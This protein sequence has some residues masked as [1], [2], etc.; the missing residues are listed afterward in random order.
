MLSGPSTDD[1]FLNDLRQAI[2]G[3]YV[4]TDAHDKEPYLADWRGYGKGEAL[5]VVL[6]ASTEQVSNLMRLA[7]IHGSKIVPPGR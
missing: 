7:D 4:L 5:A 2:G 3:Q 6:P 1:D